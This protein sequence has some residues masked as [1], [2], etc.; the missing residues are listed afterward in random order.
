M[1]E[2]LDDEFN[3]FLA[4][5]EALSIRHSDAANEPRYGNG[6]PVN[7]ADVREDKKARRKEKESVIRNA[8]SNSR[9]WTE[10]KKLD[11]TKNDTSNNNSDENR[12]KISFKIKG[13]KSKS[14]KR[15]SSSKKIEGDVVIPSEQVARNKDTSN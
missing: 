14:K 7:D 12:P 2:S 9:A 15:N 8:A 6:L 1:V 5:V 10:F 4:E 3:T 13:G 11:L